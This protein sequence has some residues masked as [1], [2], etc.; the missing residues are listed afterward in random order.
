M[1]LFGYD[2]AS[3]R[4]A[5]MYGKNQQRNHESARERDDINYQRRREADYER[6]NWENK[7]FTFQAELQAAQAE[8]R[9]P[10]YASPAEVPDIPRFAEPEPATSSD[11]GGIPRWMILIAVAY[12]G[13]LALSMILTAIAEAVGPVVAVFFGAVSFIINAAFI[14]IA[15]GVVVCT[16]LW[17]LKK[18]KAQGDPELLRTAEMWNPLKI[19]KAGWLVAKDLRAERRRKRSASTQNEAQL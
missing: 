9:R 16:V 2:S 1:P 11:G 15:V 12:I 5:D 7:K 6:Q 8:G 17:Q 18:R 13:F 14:L 10:R 4:A 19:G 3:E